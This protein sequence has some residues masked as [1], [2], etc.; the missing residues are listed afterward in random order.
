MRTG[1]FGG[2]FN[3]PH[4]GHRLALENFIACEKLDKAVVT[5][6]G[7]PPHK[8]L[9]REVPD[10]ARLEMSRLAFGDIAEINDIEVRRGGKSYTADTLRYLKETYDDLY[11]YMGSDMIL[12]VETEWRRIEEIFDMCTVTVLSRS[13][14]D[15]EKLHSYADCLGKKYGAKIDVFEVPPFEASSTEIRKIIKDG[16]DCSAYLP[17]GVEKYI[18]K[19][20]FYK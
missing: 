13:G 15:L 18:R 16:G 4:M 17:A 3:P 20:G 5:V 7:T 1:V 9:L 10:E 11:L 14:D 12:C 6:T 19:N 2:T 8:A